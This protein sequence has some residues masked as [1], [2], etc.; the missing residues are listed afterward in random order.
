MRRMIAVLGLVAVLTF[1]GCSVDPVSLKTNDQMLGQNSETENS[2][3]N[4]K[5]GEEA[6]EAYEAY[7]LLL[8]PYE[9][10]N[11]AQALIEDIDGDGIP[12]LVLV[13]DK[14][15]TV[16]IEGQAVETLR[17]VYSVY[18]YNNGIQTLISDRVTHSAPAA[19]SW[20]KI[21]I[22]RVDGRPAVV[23]VCTGE[24][25]GVSFGDDGYEGE[26]EVEALDP[27]TGEV[28]SKLAQTVQ[29]GRIVTQ[30]PENIA[31]EIRRFTALTLD[32]NGLLDFSTTAVSERLFRFGTEYNVE[33]LETAVDLEKIRQDP[34]GNYILSKDI[35]VD[36]SFQPFAEFYGILDGQGHWI[37]GFQSDLG[38]EADCGFFRTLWEGAIVRN[39]K[40]SVFAKENQMVNISASGLAGSNNGTIS[41]CLI[42][43]DITGGVV[44]SPI[45]YFNRG[46]IRNCS[47]ITM[48][49]ET[50]TLCGFVGDNYG[51]L[52]SCQADIFADS[53]NEIIG[54]ANRN[55]DEVTDCSVSVKA[56]DISLF[57][58]TSVQN[59][60]PV[61]ECEFTAWLTSPYWKSASWEIG[62]EEYFDSSNK[63]DVTSW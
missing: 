53:C 33:W 40:L 47:V 32:E 22:D 1:A 61:T 26:I 12:E 11:T 46:V 36:E 18:T 34:Y 15:V 16:M 38:N 45:A 27:Y 23:A 63:V 56:V 25:T 4:T 24:T 29:G 37:R 31:S 42:L 60:A 35:T 2:N 9:I 49:R 20:I 19:G 6:K 57:L 50:E 44:Y 28:L 30:Q 59:Y 39:L 48:A 55:W 62:A 58:C 8:E 21:G 5:N 14:P 10:S 54:L 7:D 3:Q 17:M 13:R 41:S 52:H 43:S 51:L